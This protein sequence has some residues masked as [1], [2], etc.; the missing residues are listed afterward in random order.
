MNTTQDKALAIDRGPRG[1]LTLRLVYAGNEAQIPP[2]TFIPS[3]GVTPVGREATSGVWLEQ[4]RSASRL[5]AKLHMGVLGTLR[6]V[7]EQ[8]RN[9]TFVNGRRVE[10]ALLSDGD[11]LSIGDSLLVMRAEPEGVGD[12][13]I[14]SLLGTAPSIRALRSTICRVGPAHATVVLLAESGCGKE[15]IAHALHE[16]SRRE[17]PFVAVNCSAIPENLAESELFGHVRGAFSGAL[18]DRPGHFRAAHG[19]TLFLDE[20]GDLPQVVQ[21]KLLRVLQDRTVL[22]VGAT[23]PVTCDVRVIAATNCDLKAAVEGRRFRGDLFARLSEFPMQIAPLRERREDILLLFLHA[24]GPSRPRLSSALAEALLL[25]AWPFNVRELF[26]LAQRLRLQSGDAAVLDVCH[27]A[28]RPDSAGLAF[29]KARPSEGPPSEEDQVSSEQDG[30]EP[31]PDRA[32]LEALLHAHHGVVAD[33][34]RV[35]RRSRKQVY[36]WIA[37]HGLDANRFRG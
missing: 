27:W 10:Q 28:D 16:V 19:G 5:H 9:G 7:D 14:P 24:L 8:S 3:H 21:P 11:V 17:G 13:R 22:P 23:L 2:R 31:P 37:H 15:V 29:P 6:I 35:V 36:R 12:G 4:D 20:V 32:Q 33:I 34:A 1:V 30:K 26:S 18:C 25:H